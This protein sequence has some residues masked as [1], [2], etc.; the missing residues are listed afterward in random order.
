MISRYIK[1]S[2][3]DIDPNFKG[4]MDNFSIYNRELNH[5]EINALAG[6]KDL[7]TR[8]QLIDAVQAIRK[9]YYVNISLND[10]LILSGCTPTQMINVKRGSCEDYTVLFAY[11]FR[12]LGIPSVIDFIPQCAGRS[13]GHEWN[14]LWT[15]SGRM[16]DYSPGVLAGT[17]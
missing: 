15:S 7:G 8:Q 14:V 10:R 9:L 13:G 5:A 1:K 16:E 2:L 4:E 12:S 11:I 3:I 6:K 17:P